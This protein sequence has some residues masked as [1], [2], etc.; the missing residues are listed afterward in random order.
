M[1]TFLIMYKQYIINRDIVFCDILS[2]KKWQKQHYVLSGVILEPNK[3]LYDEIVHMFV[4]KD[5]ILLNFITQDNMYNNKKVDLSACLL[6]TDKPPSFRYRKIYKRPMFKW[7]IEFMMVCIKWK[8][9]IL[10]LQFYTANVRVC[11]NWSI[12]AY[13]KHFM[14]SLLIISMTGLRLLK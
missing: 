12:N 6:K 14:Q 11:R 3:V 10:H 5:V 1:S 7:H 8:V 2:P 9:T 13:S 4:A